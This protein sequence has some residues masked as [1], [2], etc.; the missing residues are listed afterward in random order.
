M[1]SSALTLHALP[2]LTNTVFY[3]SPLQLRSEL[4]RV[5]VVTRAGGLE[6]KHGELAAEVGV[7]GVVHKTNLAIRIAAVLL[8][9]NFAPGIAEVEDFVFILIQ[10]VVIAGF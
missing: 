10:I 1:T 5:D 6:D 4:G 8:I 2:A 3:V 7:V 9:K